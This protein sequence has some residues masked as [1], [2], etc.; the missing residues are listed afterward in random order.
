MTLAGAAPRLWVTRA[1]PGASATAARLSAMGL[2]PL[3][4][5]LLEVRPLRGGPI[6]LAGV[7]ALAFTS[8]NGVTAFAGRSADRDLPVFTVGAATAAAAQ[9]AGFIR[10]T[11][12]EGDVEHLAPVIASGDWDREGLVLAPG[13]VEAAGNLAGALGAL[14]VRAR[15]LVVYDTVQRAP[16]TGTLAALHDLAGV[17]VHSPKAGKALAAVLTGHPAPAMTAYC[18][19]ANVAAPLR[20]ARTNGGLAAVLTA[21]AP[22]EAD[23]LALVTSSRVGIHGRPGPD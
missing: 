20:P 4:D 3:V 7:A 12:A 18:L 10:V 6:D 16:E 23:L 2:V 5:P 21:S 8:A 14:G 15:R 19:S 11:S 1:Q 17:L 22:T 9:R 13:P